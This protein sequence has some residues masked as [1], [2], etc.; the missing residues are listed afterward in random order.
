MKNAV[1][2]VSSL[3]C[4]FV[5]ALS[6]SA[7]ALA[8]PI[9][10]PSEGRISIGTR[11]YENST[12]STLPYLNAYWHADTFGH[13]IAE[14]FTNEKSVTAV[15]NFFS[16]QPT[17]TRFAEIRCVSEVL[18]W[19]RPHLLVQV[20]VYGVGSDESEKL[21]AYGNFTFSA[22]GKSLYEDKEAKSKTGTGGLHSMRVAAD[23]RDPQSVA[24]LRP[25]LSRA[26]MNLA[27]D[28]FA[29]AERDNGINYF[30]KN[31]HTPTN[32]NGTAHGGWIL[33]LMTQRASKIHSDQMRAI[34][35]PGAF[36]QTAGPVDISVKYLNPLQVGDETAIFNYMVS[37][38]KEITVHS[39]IMGRKAG[40]PGTGFRVAHASHR[41]P[42]PAATPTPKAAGEA[43][44]SKL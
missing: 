15:V 33:W 42:M 25:V 23:D 43:P 37:G 34:L 10:F 6:F 20:Q 12:L 18:E 26:H 7:A 35:P 27:S 13:K 39:V 3:I 32:S 5:V 40:S 19:D 2:S 41:F 22:S 14:R 9:L 1:I 17:T 24:E 29:S 8:E 36:A 30:E 11:Y 38:Q 44:R 4:M 21:I 31:E 28:L 16:M